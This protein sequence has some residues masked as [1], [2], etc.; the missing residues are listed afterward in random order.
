MVE[1]DKKHRR[2]LNLSCKNHKLREQDQLIYHVISIFPFDKILYLLGIASL[3]LFGFYKV[4]FVCIY[5][6][7]YRLIPESPRWLILKG[8]YTDA[9]HVIQ[10][11]ANGNKTKCTNKYL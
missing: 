1:N 11:I 3:Y 6:L 10:T 9:D 5:Y 2:H 4:A 7:L 8:R